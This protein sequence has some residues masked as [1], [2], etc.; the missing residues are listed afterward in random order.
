M[1]ADEDQAAASES[2]QEPRPQEVDHG[3]RPSH[4][5]DATPPTTSSQDPGPGE[6]RRD[7]HRLGPDDE[8]GVDAVVDR[9]ELVG[10]AAA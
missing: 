8:A 7:L 1:R 5:S 3:S 2:E 4:S 9:L 6:E 10:L